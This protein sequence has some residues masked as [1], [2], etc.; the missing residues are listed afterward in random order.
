MKH[1][2]RIAAAAVLAGAGALALSSTLA[3]ADS[4][5]GPGER[6][7]MRGMDGGMFGQFRLHQLDF[8]E[9]DVDGSGAITTEDLQAYS[10]SRFAEA[11]ANGDGQLDQAEIAA[12][13]T[14]RIEERGLEA[15]SRSGVRWTPTLDERQID[16]MAEGMIIRKDGDADGTISAEEAA[17]DGDRLARVIDRFDTD[18]DD[19]V[20]EVEFDAALARLTELRDGRHERRGRHRGR[21]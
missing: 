14:A 21:P 6:G 15:R 4:F 7:G 3:S 2:N 18:G 16:W 9:L 10:Q 17:P 13:I 20:S 8:A 11:D 19:G 5:G 12:R 1:I